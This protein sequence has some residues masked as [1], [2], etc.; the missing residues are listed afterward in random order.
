M[1]KRLCRDVKTVEKGNSRF[2]SDSELIQLGTVRIIPGSAIC[3]SIETP[4]KVA[5]WNLR[6]LY[7]ANG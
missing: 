7:S 5:P 3:P 6:T 2:G 4:R 1:P